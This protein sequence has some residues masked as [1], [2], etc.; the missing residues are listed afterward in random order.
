MW[1]VIMTLKSGSEVI[2]SRAIRKNGYD[3]LSPMG[4]I[5]YYCFIVTLSLRAFDCLLMFNVF[6]TFDL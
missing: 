6:E 3:F 2:D 5:S 4:M 1:K